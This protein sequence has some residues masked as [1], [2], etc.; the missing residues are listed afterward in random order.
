MS[1]RDQ[2]AGPI[3]G[4]DR[5]RDLDRDSIRR[6]EGRH[7]VGQKPGGKPTLTG[8][9]SGSPRPPGPRPGNTDGSGRSAPREVRWLPVEALTPDP[10]NAR[11]HSSRQ[12]ARIADSIAAFGFNVPVLIDEKGFVLAG[13]GRVLA[14]R[15]L[16]LDEVPTIALDHMTEA[17]SR[18]FKIADNR[19]AE[20]ASWDDGRLRLELEEL[21]ELD[22]DFALSA[23]GFEMDEIDLRIGNAGQNPG[24][25]DDRVGRD[26]PSRAVARAG[27]VWT[28]GPHRLVCGDDFDAVAFSAIDA[29]I[30]RW[31]ATAGESARL[32]PAGE[33]FA[34]VARARQGGR[35]KPTHKSEGIP[36]PL[37]GEGEGGGSGHSFPAVRTAANRKIQR[38]PPPRPAPARGAGEPAGCCSNGIHAKSAAE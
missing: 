5:G 20:L 17:E 18:A 3:D 4:A 6:N 37:V 19:L 1:N 36:S 25:A 22:L 31:Q 10:R 27:D 38:D 35:R 2:S 12:V 14:A 13:H 11:V 28:L 30:R 8:R 21:K 23:T 7:R 34:S 29:A 33:T 15:R 24:D 9:G 26:R 32:H 16:G